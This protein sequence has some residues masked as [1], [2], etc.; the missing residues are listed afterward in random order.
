MLRVGVYLS[1][2][3][4]SA[5]G[6]HIAMTISQQILEEESCFSATSFLKGNDAV[7]FHVE[8]I[9]SAFIGVSQ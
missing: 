3:A 8:K 6:F 9:S 1:A 5:Y 2:V 7:L 4:I